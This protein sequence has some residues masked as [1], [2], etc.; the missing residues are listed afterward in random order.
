MLAAESVEADDAAEEDGHVVVA[1]SWDWPFVPQ[2][3]GNRWWE[4]GVQQSG[5][6]NEEGAII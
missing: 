6:K 5:G 4:N 2:L 1:L 3:I